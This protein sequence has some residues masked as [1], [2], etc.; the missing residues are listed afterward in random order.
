MGKITALLFASTLLLSFGCQKD[1]EPTDCEKVVQELNTA[2]KGYYIDVEVYQDGALIANQ[3]NF[4]FDPQTIFLQVG[5]RSINLC[6][7]N[8]YRIVQNGQQQEL[9][10][11]Y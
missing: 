10:L 5:N 9:F 1:E 11:Y 4:N 3:D 6:E 8:S 7:L 2:L